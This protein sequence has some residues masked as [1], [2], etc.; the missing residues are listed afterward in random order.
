[1]KT[2]VLEVLKT[3]KNAFI[4]DRLSTSLHALNYKIN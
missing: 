3:D 4:N 2:Q 1:M